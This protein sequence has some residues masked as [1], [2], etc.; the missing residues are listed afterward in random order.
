[1]FKSQAEGVKKTG[2]FLLMEQLYK[3]CP[4]LNLNETNN[5]NNNLRKTIVESSKPNPIDLTNQMNE[6][7]K[8]EEDEERKKSKNNRSLRLTHN[9]AINLGNCLNN[10]NPG[11]SPLKSSLMMSKKKS[12]EIEPI[13]N[14][15]EENPQFPRV[16]TINIKPINN[17]TNTK[18]YEDNY[19]DNICRI[20]FTP[21]KIKEINITDENNHFKEYNTVL[22]PFISFIEKRHSEVEKIIPI[23]DNRKNVNAYPINIC[24]VPYYYPE[25]KYQNILIKKMQEKNKE[26]NEEIKLNKKK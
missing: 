1:M 18:T 25:N 20:I 2:A 5:I 4:T 9:T 8:S 14:Q 7:E 10:P 22:Y 13:P 6:K 11:A 24:L 16:G 19:L 3:E 15:G 26:L 12:E 21:K 23:Y 17:N